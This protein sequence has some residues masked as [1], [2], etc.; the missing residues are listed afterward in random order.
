MK[1]EIRNRFFAAYKAEAERR[2]RES[3]NCLLQIRNAAKEAAQISQ[4]KKEE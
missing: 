4:R 2:I 1:N 3:R